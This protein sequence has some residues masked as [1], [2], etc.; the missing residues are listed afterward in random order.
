MNLLNETPMKAPLKQQHHEHVKSFPPWDHPK[1]I[2]SQPFHDSAVH[3][4][5]NANNAQAGKA[6]KCGRKIKLKPQNPHPII[7]SNF[8]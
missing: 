2:P 7:Y 1:S 5:T 8:S 6:P 4:L 3:Q